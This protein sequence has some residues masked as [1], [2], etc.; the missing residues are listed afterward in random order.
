MSDDLTL[1]REAQLLYSRAPEFK[2]TGG[3]LRRWRGSIPGRGP[4]R[5]L[6]FEVE[7]VVPNG[8]P[9]IPPLVRMVTPIEHP[10]L[11]QATGTLRLTIISNWRPEYH[12]YQVINTVKGMFA[13][14]PP[15][16]G[17]GQP[18]ART[19]QP[20]AQVSIR[21]SY[22]PSPSPSPPPPSTA[23]APPPRPDD[24]SRLKQ[25][26]STLEE[27]VAHLRGK[28]TAHNVPEEGP[29]RVDQVLL[30]SDPKQRQT[31]D[32]ESDKIALEDL[33]RSLEEKY[34]SGDIAPADYARLYRK[35]KKELFLLDKKLTEERQGQ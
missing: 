11:D 7:I 3:D 33:I 14:I 28:M 13:Q 31:L 35:Y 21:Q 1:A 19:P 26:I 9:S 15:K 12:L 25:Q 30:P 16:P 8:F 24:A 17:I 34:E 10:Y 2:P 32:M 22:Q 20:Q 5:N 23:Q 4:Y 29:E 18:A 27:E 6:S